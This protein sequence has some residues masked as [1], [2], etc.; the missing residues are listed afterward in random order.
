MPKGGG[1]RD[2]VTRLLNEAEELLRQRQ[3]DYHK[4][5]ALREFLRRRLH[6]LTSVEAAEQDGASMAV[7]IQKFA[8][9]ALPVPRPPSTYPPGV[10]EVSS[11]GVPLDVL[12][13]RLGDYS[14]ELVQRVACMTVGDATQVYRAFLDRWASMHACIYAR[15]H[16][17]RGGLLA[18][19]AVGASWHAC[20]QARLVV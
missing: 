5:V 18:R 9:Q 7:L 4:A 12:P 16:A 10:L 6:L 11:N 15:M 17:G 20:T 2:R 19:P 13:T 8:M 3:I 1:T 14:L